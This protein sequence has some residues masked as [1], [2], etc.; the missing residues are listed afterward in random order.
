MLTSYDVFHSDTLRKKSFLKYTT[1]GWGCQKSEVL[2]SIL[3]CIITILFVK[4]V[5]LEEFMQQ[6]DFFVE[7][8][9]KWK[10]FIYPTD[11][12][13][14]IGGIINDITSD[15][16]KKC[17]WNR[18]WKH[19]SIIAPSIDWIKIHFEV[20]DFE[21]Y[22]DKKY[23]IAQQN[24]RGLTTILPLKAW[25]SFPWTSF[26]ENWV[27]FIDHP[28]QNFVS[29]LWEWFIT[30]SAN[31][32]WEKEISSID[33]LRPVQKKYIDYFIDAWKIDWT[34]SMIIDYTSWEVL[35]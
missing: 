12:I 23:E 25:N 30:T 10:I 2:Y 32:S 28:I 3:L 27:R 19:F 4:I 31:I 9:K 14:G 5:P 6:Y 21:R 11:T 8:A 29:Y 17:K 22:R 16:I 13:Y 24:Q 18:K 20:Y 26:P 15:N 35:R 1:Q 34:P 33:D 7:E